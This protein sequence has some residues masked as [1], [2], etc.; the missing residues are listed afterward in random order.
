[1]VR[2]AP[3]PHELA[4]NFWIAAPTNSLLLG[5]FLTFSLFCYSRWR[6]HG[7]LFEQLFVNI[8][9]KITFA[10]IVMK[11]SMLYNIESSFRCMGLFCFHFMGVPY[12]QSKKGEKTGNLVMG[13]I[14]WQQ[15]LLSVEAEPVRNGKC[16]LFR[17]ITDT[18]QDNLNSLS[19]SELSCD[20][21]GM[22]LL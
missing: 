21:R 13:A 11:D 19:L 14:N 12:I 17:S 18:R 8:P 4:V 6:G 2:N 22:A 9:L 10:K 1:M 5:G 15:S 16:L 20:P 7:V 3:I